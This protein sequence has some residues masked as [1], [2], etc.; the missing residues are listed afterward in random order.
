[1][2]SIQNT[3]DFHATLLLAKHR[4]RGVFFGHIHQNLDIYRDGILYC[5]TP[6]SWAQF[7]AYP[8]QT[9]LVH[10]PDAGSGF[11]VVMVYQHQTMIRRYRFTVEGT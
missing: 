9:E 5:T 4:V 3:E 11:S 8:G 1:V 2:T 10:D 6:G 7:H